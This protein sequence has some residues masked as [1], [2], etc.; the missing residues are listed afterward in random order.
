VWQVASIFEIVLQDG[1]AFMFG[2]IVGF[3]AAHRY[4][5]VREQRPTDELE[6][7]A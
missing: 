5:L 1:G 6:D 3:L 7:G 2:L 4:R